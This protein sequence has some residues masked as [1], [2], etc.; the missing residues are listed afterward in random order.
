[1]IEI[2]QRTVASIQRVL[3]ER[4]SIHKDAEDKW[5]RLTRIGRKA[6]NSAFL[7]GW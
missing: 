3:E 4:E 5:N 6:Q 7:K 1:M 2:I